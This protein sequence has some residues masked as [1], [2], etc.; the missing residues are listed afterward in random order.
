MHVVSTSPSAHHC[1]PARLYPRA[2]PQACIHDRSDST[3]N[4]N[5]RIIRVIKIFRILR[6]V[7]VLKL[8]N[9][10]VCVPRAP[11]PRNRRTKPRRFSEITDETSEVLGDPCTGP[12]ILQTVVIIVCEASQTAQDGSLRETCPISLAVRA[13]W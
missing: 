2:I 4:S 1:A 3:T 6:I 10:I 11:S 8:V 9:V 7:R 5:A 13:H 12:C